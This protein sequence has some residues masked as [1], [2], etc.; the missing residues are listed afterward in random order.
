[1]GAVVGERCLELGDVCPGGEVGRTGHHHGTYRRILGAL[2]RGVQILAEPT[3]QG[4]HRGMIERDDGDRTVG[5]V[6]DQ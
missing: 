6:A 3:R 5:V 1:V 4:V 2:D